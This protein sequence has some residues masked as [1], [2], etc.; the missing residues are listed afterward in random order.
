MTNFDVQLGPPSPGWAFFAPALF[1]TINQVHKPPSPNDRPQ[2][3][4]VST[5]QYEVSSHAVGWALAVLDAWRGRGRPVPRGRQS[6]KSR[7][8]N[9]KGRGLESASMSQREVVLFLFGAAVLTAAAG[10]GVIV[11]ALRLF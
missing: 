5:L 4:L 3:I 9:W 7:G 1:K 11:N 8:Q 2:S 10:A 6:S